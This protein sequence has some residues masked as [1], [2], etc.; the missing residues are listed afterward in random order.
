MEKRHLSIQIGILVALIF[1]ATNPEITLAQALPEQEPASAQPNG[2]SAIPLELGSAERQLSVA[3]L[4]KESG[5]ETVTVA[6]GNGTVTFD[7]NSAVTAGQYVAALQTLNNR[8]DIVKLDSSGVVIGGEVNLNGLSLASLGIP[9][10]VLVQHDF[11]ASSILNITGNFV[12]N[13]TFLANTTI[14]N[15]TGLINAANITNFGLIAGEGLN[16]AFNTGVFSNYGTITST[17]DL[18]VAANSIING[19]GSLLQAQGNF[20]AIASNIFNAGVMEIGGNVTFAQSALLASLD[21][22]TTAMLGNIN[23]KLSSEFLLNNTG[24]EIRANSI[25]IRAA[26]LTKFVNVRGGDFLSNVL[27]VTA[28]GAG[29]DISAGNITG[30]LHLSGVESH[31]IVEASPVLSIGTVCM[32]GDPTFYNTAGD[33]VINGDLV[34]NGAPLALVASRDILTGAGGALIDTSSSTG[35]GGDILLV[36]GAKFTSDGAPGVLPPGAGDNSS[37]I[38]ITG[39]SASG[40]NIDLS[41]GDPVFNIMSKSTAANGSGGNIRLVAFSGTGGPGP[42]GGGGNIK[43]NFTSFYSA[44]NGTGKNGDVLMIAGAASGQTLTIGD[45]LVTSVGATGGGGNVQLRTATPTITGG[46]ACNPC[47]EVRNGAIIGGAF[48]VGALQTDATLGA[49]SQ[50]T[51]SGP[52]AASGTIILDNISQ[53]RP[54]APGSAVSITGAGDITTGFIRT[55]GGGGFSIF[56]LGF[57]GLDG[58]NVSITSNF[59]SITVN[60]DINTSGGGGGGAIIGVGAAGNG[61]NAGSVSLVSNSLV[62][63][64]GPILAAGGGG[65]TLST[66]AFHAGGGSLGLGGLGAINGGG[67]GGGTIGAGGGI[68]ASN[69]PNHVGLPG[70]AR[71]GSAG[72]VTIVAPDGISIT[73][74]AGAIYGLTGNAAFSPFKQTAVYGHNVSMGALAPVMV[75]GEVI[76]Q[77]TQTGHQPDFDATLSINAPSAQL[78]DISYMGAN[79][80]GNQFDRSLRINVLNNL[81]SGAVGAR[82]GHVFGGPINLFASSATGSFNV[83]NVTTVGGGRVFLS[84]DK[85]FVTTG[86]IHTAACGGCYGVDGGGVGIRARAID[87]GYIFTY[88][89]GGRLAEKGANGG[90]VVLLST[91]GGISVGSFGI[92]TSGGGSGGRDTSKIPFLLPKSGGDAGDVVIAAAGNISINGPIIAM[93]GGPGDFDSGGGSFGNGG[94]GTPN[95]GG[96]NHF[97]TTIGTNALISAS[98]VGRS[99]SGKAGDILIGGVNLTFN[100][101]LGTAYGSLANAISSP[102]TSVVLAGHNMTLAASGPLLVPGEILVQGRPDVDPTAVEYAVMLSLIIVVCITAIATLGPDGSGQ[103]TPPRPEGT[104]NENTVSNLLFSA[105]GPVTLG[106]VTFIGGSF[107]RNDLVLSANTPSFT[108]GNVGVLSAYAVPPRSFNVN[109]GNVGNITTGDIIAPGSGSF[110]NMLSTEG[111]ITAGNLTARGGG[112]YLV[113]LPTNKTVVTGNLDSTGTTGFNNH[114]GFVFIHGGAGITTGAINTYGFESTAQQSNG[115]NGGAVYLTSP[116]GAITINGAVNTSGGGSSGSSF[117]GTTGGNGGSVFISAGDALTIH[118]PVLSPGG[119]RGAFNGGVNPNGGGSL[120]IGGSG[121]GGG[122]NRAT[123]GVGGQAGTIKGTNAGGMDGG[124]SGAEQLLGGS[125]VTITKNVGQYY[126]LQSNANSSPYKD[127]FQFTGFIRPNTPSVQ[128]PTAPPKTPPPPP[129]PAPAVQL[130]QSITNATILATDTLNRQVEFPEAIKDVKKKKAPDVSVIPGIHLTVR[131]YIDGNVSAELSEPLSEVDDNN[132][133]RPVAHAEAAT[134]AG[135][136]AVWS[137]EG[138]GFFVTGGSNLSQRD[139]KQLALRQGEI[140]TDGKSAVTVSTEFGDVKIKTGAIVI[141]SAEPGHMRIVDVSD[142][143]HGDVV[144]Q[145]GGRLVRLHPGAELCI[146]TKGEAA[147][148]KVLQDGLARRRMRQYKGEG[149]LVMITSDCSLMDA[150]S[151]HSLLK[152]LNGSTGA[153]KAISEKVLKTAAALMRATASHGAYTSERL[154]GAETTVPQR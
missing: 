130:V 43:T 74:G 145:A 93:G 89:G 24:G 98:N 100:Q 153:N 131:E 127:F 7:G 17:G 4:L 109:I 56:G 83:G 112:I 122:L 51:I 128:I 142:N 45:A 23:S 121:N 71:A 150:L 46:G 22:N 75:N 59:G 134:L 63:V 57:N 52:T 125:T 8:S 99:R 105:T 1:N 47:V 38:S 149:D 119:G 30:D 138:R 124:S 62:T 31:V 147:R 114:G 101:T 152:Q 144:F 55:Y 76:L 91:N 133:F 2:S 81:Q 60:G 70:D 78:G 25:N 96:L 42:A 54:S 19:Q 20:A 32:T 15:V 69:A 140:M 111:N 154:D 146:S 64:N 113:S 97:G 88:G 115:G 10:N 18:T 28:P 126:G 108:F 39:A 21:S 80:N 26:E 90:D 61:G 82:T 77:G 129:I 9:E 3:G 50:L 35:N 72:D 37:L 132:V 104:L 116:G 33:I 87:T 102:F 135:A 118:G 123:F 120:G 6:Q 53:L 12:N 103:F 73:A 85:G 117:A 137:N 67:L 49:S 139:E 36:A 94:I 13:G 86:N 41:G 136:S 151:R 143:N 92:N 11:G 29:I 34:F 148:G 106:N 27:D 16:L 141:V 79:I 68:S 14:E 107:N 66:A 95:G 40:G 84:A 44:G 48:G 65:G 5:A 58:G 110:I